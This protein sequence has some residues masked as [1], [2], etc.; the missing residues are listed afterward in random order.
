MLSV[1]PVRRL[2]TQTTSQPFARKKSQRWEPMNPAPPVMRMRGGRRDADRRA[3][4]EEE[5]MGPRDTSLMRGETIPSFAMS[6]VPASAPDSLRGRRWLWVHA[7][8]VV[9]ATPP[10]DDALLYDSIATRLT[11]G[12]PYVDA[13]GYRSRRAPGFPI[14]LAG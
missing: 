12:G 13:E 14:L 8:V 11:Q 10:R 1:V 5:L 3:R 4:R 6:T 7:A 2:S 9:L